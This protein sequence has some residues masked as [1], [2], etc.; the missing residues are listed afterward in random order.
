MEKA[1]SK[2]GETGRDPKLE[3]GVTPSDSEESGLQPSKMREPILSADLGLVNLE[4][5]PAILPGRGTK[6]PLDPL[7]TEGCHF[8]GPR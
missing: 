1:T 2:M 4:K 5:P 3:R 7:D 6:A 8:I